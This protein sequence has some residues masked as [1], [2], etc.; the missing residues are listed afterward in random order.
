MFCRIFYRY[1]H[2]KLYLTGAKK[3]E[4]SQLL[5]EDSLGNYISSTEVQNGLLNGLFDVIS[6][7]TIRTNKPEIRVIALK[8]DDLATYT[9]LRVWFDYP[10]SSDSTPGDSNI[11]YFKV[12]F[13]VPKIDGCGD[14]YADAVNKYAIPYNVTLSQAD[15]E[16]NAITLPNVAVGSYLIIYLQRI[17]DPVLQQPMSDDDLIEILEGTLV[18]DKEEEVSLRINSD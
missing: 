6:L 11:A 12:G 5:P 15:G 10:D 14:L 9:N 18:L 4:N 3:F 7:F 2:M 16:A 13:S 8:N 1:F 17:L